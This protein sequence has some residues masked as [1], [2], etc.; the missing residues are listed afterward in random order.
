M[1]SPHELP[2]PPPLRRPMLL[3]GG[4]VDT[5]LGS[6]APPPRS[7]PLPARRRSLYLA[8]RLRFPMALP[9]SPCPAPLPDDRFPTHLLGGCCLTHLLG[10]GEQR[11]E[12]APS[13]AAQDL[14]PDTQAGVAMAPAAVD[15]PSPL[16]K[17]RRRAP[18]GGPYSFV[19]CCLHDR[20]TS[21][22]RIVADGRIGL[23][24]P[25]SA[26][27]HHA[28]PLLW[29]STAASEIFLS[30]E[31]CI[32]PSFPLQCEEEEMLRA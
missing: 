10:T 15:H 18:H 14:P 28:E 13:C 16:V 11:R 21:P 31:A 27:E 30:G 23:G 2:P 19:P 17:M 6:V 4:S 26:T 5:S 9:T 12:Q 25:A 1:S 7:P 22:G 8:A 20:M 32:L 3:P 24:R 29:H